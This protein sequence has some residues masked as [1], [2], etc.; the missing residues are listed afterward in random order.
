MHPSL[1]RLTEMTTRNHRLILGLMS[2]TSLDG[3]DIALCKIEGFG[4]NTQVTC[5]HHK[6][7]SYS[8]SFRTKLKS[9]YANTMIDAS[10]ICRLNIEIAELH[11]EMALESLGEWNIQPGDVDLLSSHGQTLFHFPKSDPNNQIGRTYTWQIG[12][13]D[14][15]AMRTGII[16]LSDFRQKQLAAGGEG[17]P[18]AAY[19][20]Y[21]LFQS[22][23]V[24]RILLNLGGIA[25]LTYLPKGRNFSAVQCTDIGPANGLMDRW[26]KCHWPE[27]NYDPSG[28]LAQKGKLIPS[29]LKYLSAH[30]FF[31]LPFPKSTGPE[32]FNDSFLDKALK[33]MKEELNPLDVLCTLNTWTAQLVLEAIS[34]FVSLNQSV[35][36]FVSG[37]G[38]YNE[39]LMQQIRSGL[40]S[41][42]FLKNPADLGIPSDAKEAILFAVLANETVCGSNAYVPGTKSHPDVSMG[43]I[44]L[45]V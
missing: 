6:T 31:N 41:N 40:P 24:D 18:L 25:N 37:G 3:L 4:K 2:G 35:E 8:D 7:L 19:G 43:K 44:S 10:E 27:H 36:I 15:L 1:Q 14:H 5:L 33:Q 26:V 23:T 34:S 9:C 17:A 11:A 12:D 39:T 20:D 22:E 28:I 13:G 45:P 29:L 16:T 32:L 30:V 38:R 21:I 42:H